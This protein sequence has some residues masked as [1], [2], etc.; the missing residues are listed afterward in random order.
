MNRFRV[1][2]YIREHERQPARFYASGRV[3]A[4]VR[5]AIR[6][7]GSIDKYGDPRVSEIRMRER[8]SMKSKMLGALALLTLVG[9]LFVMQSAQQHAPT[10]DAATGSIAARNVGTC[11]TTD[12]TVF[13]GD[14]EGLSESASD[15]TSGTAWEVRGEIGEVSTLYATYAHDPKTSSDAPRAILM[16][17]DLL[18]ISIADSGRDKRSPILVR[19]VTRVSG[20]DGTATEEGAVASIQ[21]FLASDSGVSIIG[22]GNKADVTKKPNM[23]LETGQQLLGTSGNTTLNFTGTAAAH[24]PMDVAGNIRFFGCTVQSG[25]STCKVDGPDADIDPDELQDVSGSIQVDEDASSGDNSDK[26]VAPWLGVNASVPA[27][28]DILIYAIYFETS[29]KE[30]LVGGTQYCD[31]D[32]DDDDNCPTPAT[33][34]NDG[35]TNVVYTS[36]EKNKNTAL[37]VHASSDGDLEERG[38]DLYLTETKRFSGEY[39]GHLRLTDANGDGRGSGSTPM[40]WGRE[41]DDGE[42]DGAAV[43]AVDQGPVIIEYRDSDGKKQTLRIEIDNVAPTINVAAPANGSSSDDQSPDFAGTLEDTNSGLADN[44]FR[45]VADNEVDGEGK[46]EDYVLHGRAPAI[47]VTSGALASITRISEYMGYDDPTQFGIVMAASDLYDLDDDSCDNQELCHILADSYD[48]GAM[49]GTFDDDIRLDLQDGGKD[50]VTRDREFEI[51]FQAFVMDMAGNIGFSD[52]DPSNPRYINDLGEKDATKRKPGNVLG[53]YSAHIITLDEKDPDLI[54]A[55]SATG[56]YGLNSDGKAMPDRS[57]I[58]VEFD[59]PIAASSVS[60]NTFSVKLDDG[61][62]ATVVDVDVDKKYVFLKLGAELAS[63]ATP[64]IDIVQ[65]EKVE[66]M[67]GNETFGKEQDEFEAQDGISPKLTVT[68]SGGSGIG[69][70]D[71]GPEKLTK[72]QITVNVSS[73]EELQGAPRIAVVCSSLEWNEGTAGIEGSS[74][75]TGKD[76]D[77]Y[78]ANRSGAMSG[79]QPGETPVQTSPRAS[80]SDAQGE[81]YAYTCGY[82]AN[83]DNFDDDIDVD[84]NPPSALSR[85]GE[86]WDYTWKES[87]KFQDGMLTVVAFARDRSRYDHMDDTNVQNWGSTS[88]EFMLDTVLASPLNGGGEVQPADGGTSKETRPFVLIGFDESTSVTLDSVQLDDVEIASEFEQPETNRFVY[89]PLT[90]TRGDHEVEVEASDAAGNEQ[91]FEFSF[92]V[93]ERG[94]FLLNLLAGWNAISVPADPV[95]TAIGAVFTNPSI[96]TVIGWDT[97]GW[98]IAVRRDGVWESNHQYGTLNEIRAKYG[99]W[100]KSNNFVRQPIALTANDRGVGGPRTP[101]A[102]DTKPGWNFVGVIDQ[103]GDQTEGD[104]GNGLKDS[105]N[106]P[107]NAAEY[108]GSNYVRAYTWDATFNRFDTLRPDVQMMIGDGVWVYYQGGIAP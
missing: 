43:L 19:S 103:D 79:S 73:D 61:S 59:G 74:G 78:V 84:N 64:Q 80:K 94:D 16:N 29:S 45:L 101:L 77:D 31:V 3:Y 52:S 47:N 67:A 81:T 25:T 68:L 76:I 60:T 33:N 6:R 41:V 27:S 48:D 56:Y 104:S 88:A 107:I 58:M 42:N 50:A 4:R 32:L 97:D 21:E 99:Y 12:A 39:R 13:K 90:L 36:D 108:L 55:R 53:Y 86:N 46:N 40:D 85:P 82:D 95:D 7:Q 83:D 14:C 71:E 70:G 18:E 51:D 102:I 34:A 8:I 44:S 69:T 92:K 5:E 89:W 105:D 57:G 62:D 28:R 22:S 35:V 17:S 98:R 91:S 72:N 65:G 9:T 1:D 66:D 15:A 2:S 30:N 10:A 11:L 93:E 23:M 26:N 20:G 100:V 75:L 87:G 24:D 38:V 96:D 37:L 54:E 106:R 49:R 63:D